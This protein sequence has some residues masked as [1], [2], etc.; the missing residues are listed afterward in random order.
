MAGEPM[1]PILNDPIVKAIPWAAIASHERQAGTNHGQTL[2]GLAARGGLSVVEAVLVMRDK[3][4]P[5][6][7]KI[8]ALQVAAYRTA[9]MND[10]L[11]FERERTPA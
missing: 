2:K 5:R 6:G 4:W 11:K 7:S 9:L 10:L 1:Y 8:G 3:P